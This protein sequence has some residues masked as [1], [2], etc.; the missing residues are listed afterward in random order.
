[1]LLQWPQISLNNTGLYEWKTVYT[2]GHIGQMALRVAF[3]EERAQT[4]QTHPLVR[5]AGGWGV[6]LEAHQKSADASTSHS[7]RQNVAPHF[8]SSPWWRQVNW[9]E[10]SN[11]RKNKENKQGEIG[12]ITRALCDPR[13]MVRNLSSLA[14]GWACM[15]PNT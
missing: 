1:M 11:N 5:G 2:R 10:N 3:H 13:Q 6:P 4:S 7:P 9:L 12:Y 15:L 14:E 8:L